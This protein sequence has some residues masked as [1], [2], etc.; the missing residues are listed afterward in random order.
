M[1]ST[2]F[3]PRPC[4]LYRQLPCRVCAPLQ[5]LSSFQD[6]TMSFVDLARDQELTSCQ[7]ALPKARSVSWMGKRQHVIEKPM[8]FGGFKGDG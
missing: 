8:V 6:A 5:D 1:E 3:Q 2:V 4:D 7:C